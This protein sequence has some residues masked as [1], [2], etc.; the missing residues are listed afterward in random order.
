ME[1]CKDFVV[2]DCSMPPK[3]QNHNFKMTN[4]LNILHVLMSVEKRAKGKSEGRIEG[5]RASRCKKCSFFGKSGVL[6]FLETPVLRFALL[7]YYR[8]KSK[9]ERIKR[10]Q[11][12]L[13]RFR[14]HAYLTNSKL[15]FCKQICHYFFKRIAGR[16]WTFVFNQLGF[17]YLKSNVSDA[18]H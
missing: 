18:Y 8:F 10:I 1:F 16:M 2:T 12:L 6:C 14:I 5:E 3:I 15:F 13:F 7:P 4:N 17:K 11:K 9:L